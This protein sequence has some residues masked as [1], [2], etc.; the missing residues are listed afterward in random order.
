MI[1]NKDLRIG[2][3][4]TY[5]PDSLNVRVEKLNEYFIDG[6]A[7]SFY[8]GIPISPDIL[9][10][11]GASNK[12]G[13]VWFIGKLKFSYEINELSQFVRFHY[14]GK[15]AYLQYLHELQNL[16]KILTQKELEINL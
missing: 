5:I 14:S 15:V 11:C 8:K 13:N 4:V 1:S 12:Y 6:V 3:W 16:V 2:N 7:P 9:V 10:K